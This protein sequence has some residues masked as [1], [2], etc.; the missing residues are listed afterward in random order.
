MTLADLP[1][2]AALPTREK[3]ILLEELRDAIA[4]EEGP[5]PLTPEQL[6]ELNRRRAAFEADPSSAVS[7][8]DVKARCAAWKA[9]NGA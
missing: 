2:V 5:G 4:L 6:A 1:A 8:D 7:W 9:S 3:Q